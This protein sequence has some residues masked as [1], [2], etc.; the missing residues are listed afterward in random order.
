MIIS[1]IPTGIVSLIHGLRVNTFFNAGE[2]EKA[3]TSSKKAKFWV[4]ISFWIGIILLII[5]IKFM[6][7]FMRDFNAQT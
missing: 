5:S 6:I 4:W 2:Y 1:L 7:G 3:K